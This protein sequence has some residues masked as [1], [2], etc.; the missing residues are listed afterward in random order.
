MGDYVIDTERTS[1][2]RG[3]G[4]TVNAVRMKLRMIGQ[5][6]WTGSGKQT[7][8]QVVLTDEQCNERVRSGGERCVERTIPYIC[9]LSPTRASDMAFTVCTVFQ[10]NNIMSPLHL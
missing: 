2:R 6:R 3:R 4:I 1:S 7:T 9:A 5:R 10:N 8:Q